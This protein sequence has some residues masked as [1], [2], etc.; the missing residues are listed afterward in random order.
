M[1]DLFIAVLSDIHGNLEALE[2]VLKSLEEPAERA[3]TTGIDFEIWCLGDIFGYGPDP[4]TCFNIAR[5]RFKIILPG[6]HEA[7]TRLKLKYPDA[8][9]TGVSLDAIKSCEYTIEQL[10]GKQEIKGER[11]GQSIKIPLETLESM[12][13]EN[14][15]AM[16]ASEIAKKYVPEIKIS[17]P[18]IPLFKKTIPKEQLEQIGASYISKVLLQHEQLIDEYDCRIKRRNTVIN[19]Y[20]FL[21][22]IE[23]T[24]TVKLKNA[25]F[26]HDDPVNPGSMAYLI[27]DEKAEKIRI[28]NRINLKLV[29]RENLK[30][31]ELEYIF[32]GHSHLMPDTTEINGIKTVYVGSVGIP[33]RDNIEKKACYTAVMV[34]D[35]KVMQT[36]P[37]IIS[38]EYTKTK[39]KMIERGLPDKF[40]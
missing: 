25:I 4:L 21:E 13:K 22:N 15:Q 7:L 23:K 34:R 36:K 17:T 30:F 26:V 40:D 1:Q 18:E 11:T 14:Y 6:N 8:R 38:Y 24:R 29:T 16:L 31:P 9:P 28:R 3:K 20:N 32:V 12:Q 39:K 27:D 5:E 2:A 33:R 10:L 37:V 35:E 19:L